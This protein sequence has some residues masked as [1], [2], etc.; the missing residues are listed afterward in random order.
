[1]QDQ[2]DILVLSTMSYENATWAADIETLLPA[3]LHIRTKKQ[4]IQSFLWTDS[5][6]PP[7]YRSVIIKH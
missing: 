7:S 1:M 5:P 3:D 4:F 6:P 2:T